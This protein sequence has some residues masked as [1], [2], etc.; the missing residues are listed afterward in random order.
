MREVFSVPDK[1]SG[2]ISTDLSMTFKGQVYEV[3]GSTLDILGHISGW[4]SVSI[5]EGYRMGHYLA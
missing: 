3:G 1:G 5:T 2:V 4:G